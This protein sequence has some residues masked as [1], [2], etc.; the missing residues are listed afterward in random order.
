M[1]RDT[2]NQGQNPEPGDLG[3]GLTYSPGGG[4]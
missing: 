3:F 1:W 4:L 2:G